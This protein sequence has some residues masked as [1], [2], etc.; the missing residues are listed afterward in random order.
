MPSILFKPSTALC[1]ACTSD[2]QDFNRRT[3]CGQGRLPMAAKLGPEILSEAAT[4]GPGG[5][6]MGNQQ[7]HDMP[8]KVF[9]KV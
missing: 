7:W 5:T 1:M 4:L 6:I 8:Q 2:L 9:V 3:I